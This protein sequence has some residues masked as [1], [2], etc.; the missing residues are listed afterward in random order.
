MPLAPHTGTKAYFPG[1]VDAGP[2]EAAVSISKA[3]EVW[4]LTKPENDKWQSHLQSPFQ[5][6]L[7]HSNSQSL[8]MR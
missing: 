2:H 6:W 1:S 8:A 5:E 3:I 7:G 4:A